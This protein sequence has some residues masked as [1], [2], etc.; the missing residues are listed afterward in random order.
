MIGFPFIETFFKSILSKSEAIQG[1][2]FFAPKYGHEI[3]SDELGRVLDENKPLITT[4][5]YPLAMCMPPVYVVDSAID[6][7]W[8]S[9]MFRMFFLKPS[10]YTSDNQVANPNQYT[11]TSQHSLMFDW[12][13]MARC[14]ENFLRALKMVQKAKGLQGTSFRLTT[15]KKAI[16][17]PITNIGIDRASGV[18]LDFEASVFT[19][20]E[21]EDYLSEE[22]LS[23]NIEVVDTHPQHKI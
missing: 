22:L 21:L 9:F 7:S 1:R 10:F 3:N 16:V 15:Q 23:L 17:T 8:K 6:D 19:G 2:F 5:K 11:G 14:S 12:H 4:Q 20:C 13:D 18:R